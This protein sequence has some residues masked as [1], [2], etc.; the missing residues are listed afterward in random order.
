[1]IIMTIFQNFQMF[2][3]KIVYVEKKFY[4]AFQN[5]I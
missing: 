4:T 2:N 5:G 3:N 1:M